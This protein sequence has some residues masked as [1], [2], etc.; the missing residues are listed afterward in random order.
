MIKF[1]NLFEYAR[2]NYQNELERKEKLSQRITTIFNF[3]LI[4][5]GALLTVFFSSVDLNTI[6]FSNC[7]LISISIFVF[8]ISYLVSFVFFIRNNFGEKYDWLRDYELLKNNYKKYNNEAKEEMKELY[9]E[10]G[11]SDDDVLMFRLIFNY[12]DAA[13]ALRSVSAKHNKQILIISISMFF[14]TISLIATLIGL[15]T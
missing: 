14:S 7:A 4:I 9:G 2:N 8:M 5:T 3:Q 10:E 12:D 6:D 11:F 13:D 15:L 1:D